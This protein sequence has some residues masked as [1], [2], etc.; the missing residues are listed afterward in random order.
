MFLQA[1]LSA[2]VLGFFAFAIGMFMLGVQSLHWV[3]GD[4]YDTVGFVLMAFV[5]PLEL[6]AGIIAFFTRDTLAATVLG[7]FATSWLLLGLFL[8]TS[9]PHELNHAVGFFLFVFSSVTL[10]LAIVAT[11]GKPL[12][13][14]LLTLSTARA[15]LAGI[16]EFSGGQTVNGAAGVVALALCA[17]AVY[18]GLALLFEDVLQQSRLPVFRR[19]AARAAMEGD[20]REQLRRLDGEAGVRQQL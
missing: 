13:A 9:P 18:G 1:F 5:F 11:S 10:S 17:I 15:I 20:L 2:V 19:G 3:R 8:A 4:E 14:L 7:L 16:H 6:I 12:F